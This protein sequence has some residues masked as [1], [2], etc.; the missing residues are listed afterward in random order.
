MAGVQKVGVVPWQ[1][2]CETLIEPHPLASR[3][4]LR[5]CRRSTLSN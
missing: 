2:A 5:F 1:R 3:V 4:V